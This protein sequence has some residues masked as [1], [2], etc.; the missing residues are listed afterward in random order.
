MITRLFSFEQMPARGVIVASFDQPGSSEPSKAKKK[1]AAGAR[2]VGNRVLIVGR[3]RELAVY[4]A[5]FLRQEGFNVLIAQ[6]LDEAIRVMQRGGFDALILSYTIPSREAQYLADAARDYHAD[7]AII[8]VSSSGNETSHVEPDAI[9]PADEGPTG[10]IA[11]LKR[12]LE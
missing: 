3:Q 11:A 12:V 5:E 4:R 10:L 2:G 7:C 8:A 6:D 1:R 9:A